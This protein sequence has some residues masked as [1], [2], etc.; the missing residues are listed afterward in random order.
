ME[1]NPPDAARPPRIQQRPAPAGVF[2]GL[3][4]NASTYLRDWVT[5]GACPYSK[6]WQAAVQNRLQAPLGVL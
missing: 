3:A 2:A 1:H 4:P 6:S 5:A